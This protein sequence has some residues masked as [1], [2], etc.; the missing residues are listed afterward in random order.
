MA[1]G[2]VETV[3]DR[4]AQANAGEQL[5]KDKDALRDHKEAFAQGAA[6][7][8]YEVELKG[9]AKHHPALYPHYL[10][11]WDADVKYPPTEREL[12]YLAGAGSH[13]DRRS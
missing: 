3:P 13:A 5:I 8:N 10:P 4:T 12:K 9:T 1:P 11:Y 2:L 6:S 7:T